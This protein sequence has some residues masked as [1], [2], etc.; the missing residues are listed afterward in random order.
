MGFVVVISLPL[1][2]FILILALVCYM[3]GRAKGRR[4]NPQQYGPPV[5]PA[6]AQP[7]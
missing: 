7:K 4:Q 2:L 6:Q 1:I 5:P 3:L